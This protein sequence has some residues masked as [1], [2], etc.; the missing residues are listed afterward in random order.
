MGGVIQGTMQQPIPAAPAATPEDKTAI[1]RLLADEWDAL[2]AA[3]YAMPDET[4]WA[5]QAP[6]K[7]CPAEHLHHLLRS[8]RI[9][10]LTLRLPRFVLRWQWGKPNRPSRTYQQLGQRYDERLAQVPPGRT[11][12]F[13]P[14]LEGANRFNKDLLKDFMHE[15]D[16]LL[17][18]LNQWREADLDRYLVGHPLLGRITARELF[19]F[20]AYHTRHHRELVQAR[21]Q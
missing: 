10:T 13:G 17:R 15:K 11:N 2:T 14:Q 3:L 18:T 6:G 5:P 1:A 19:M 12:R 20:T 21:S 16:R 7:W 8:A 9:T 4:F